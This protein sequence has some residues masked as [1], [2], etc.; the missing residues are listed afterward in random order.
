MNL[1]RYALA[2]R[3]V[4]LL[5]TPL[6]EAGFELLDVRVFLGGGRLTLRLFLDA[7]GGMTLANCVKASRTAE[8]LIEEADIVAESYVIEASSPGIRRPLRTPAHFLAAVGRDISLKLKGRGR[9][10]QLRGRLLACG[11]DGLR[12]D[13]KAAGKD[14]DAVEQNVARGE[15]LEANLDADFDAQALINADRRRRKEEKRQVRAARRR[16]TAGSDPEA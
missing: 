7:E 15:I 10:R 8:M 16:D 3:L 13:V 9:P 11:D 6:R 1:D 5:E 2:D 14:A 12:V 4:A